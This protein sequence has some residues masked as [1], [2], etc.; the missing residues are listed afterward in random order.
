MNDERKSNGKTRPSRLWAAAALLGCAGLAAA[1]PPAKPADVFQNGKIWTVHLK[2]TADQ[3]NAIEPK[4]GGFPGGPGGPGAPGGPGGPGGPGSFGPAMFLAPAFLK[5]DTNHDGKLSSAEFNSLG[6][7]WFTAWDK[8]KTGRLTPEQLRNGLNSM[9]DMPGRGGPGGGPDGGPG[10]P[11]A[12]GAGQRNGISAMSG[13]NFEYVRADLDFD[14]TPFRDVAVRYKGN[15]SYMEARNSIKK[16]LKIDLNKYVKGQKLAGLTKINLHNNVTDASWMNEPLSYRLFRDAGVPSPRTSYAR[17]YVTVPGK[18]DHKYFGL[19]SIVE[20]VDKHFAEE[21]FGSRKGAIFKPVGRNLFEDM[22][23]DWSRYQR[24]YDPKD[25]PSPKQQKRVM[26][27]AHFVSTANDA[28]FAAGLKDYLDLD[29]FARFMA[30][31]VW[32]SNMDSLLS[33]GQNYYVYLHP[34]TNRFLFLPWDLDHSFGQFPMGGGTGLSIQHPWQGQNRFLERV[35]QVGDFKKLYLARLAEINKTVGQPAR[36]S[37]QVD[38]IAAL[39]RPAV[40]EESAEKLARF[41]KAVSGQ[42]AEPGGF[43]GGEGPGGPPPG[44]Q[45][46][47]MGPRMGGMKPIKGFVG[48][49]SASVAAQLAGKSQ[50][51]TTAD[52]G[53]GGM[54]GPGGMPGPGG[55]GPA[56]FLAPVFLQAMG[57]GQNGAITQEQFTRGFTKWFASWGGAKTGF[58]TEEQLR[59]GINRDLAPRGMPGGPPPMPR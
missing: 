29:E 52:R 56:T 49:R 50:G 24:M 32:L 43:P 53:P 8:Q 15:N 17:V 39:I 41:E 46:G 30:A 10:F 1:E 58:L 25:D 37:K 20:D 40:K 36:L 18:Y 54:G 33:M 4:G 6:N 27:F 35:F 14:G 9:V 31:T 59:S 28:A 38:E 13:I 23:S 26:E 21:R 7:S 42:S 44:G 51:D 3:W 45:G 47:R 16:S 34:E 12:G 55:M 11:P 5:A 2:F 22:G 57:A 48:P 19:Y